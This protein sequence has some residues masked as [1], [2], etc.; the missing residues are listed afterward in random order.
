MER[1]LGECFRVLRNRRYLALYVSDSWKKRKGGPKGSGA[2]TF[3]PIGF[4]LFSIMRRH[5][6]AVDIVTVVRQNAKL[7]KGNWHKVAEEENFFLR[8]FNYLFIMKKVVDRPD[9]PRPGASAAA[10]RGEG[11]MD[12]APRRAP[13]GRS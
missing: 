2:G 12:R 3:M 6:E 11:A 9:G 5:F 10:A 13:R 8:G 1:E 4:E 7:G